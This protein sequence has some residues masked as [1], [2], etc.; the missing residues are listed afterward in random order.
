MT[1][2]KKILKDVSL[3]A[4]AS[5]GPKIM[6]FF[7]VPL[8]TS[9]LT[10]EAYGTADLLNTVVSLIL[11]I[12]MIDISD[13]IIIRTVE[14]RNEDRKSGSALKYGFTIYGKSAVVL[15]C[16]LFVASILISVEH[17]RFYCLYIFLQYSTLAIYNNLIAYLRG[18]DKAAI[19]VS[20]SLLHSALTIAL[21]I[22]LILFLDFGLLGLLI[23]GIVGGAITNI[24]LILR[25]TLHKILKSCVPISSEEKKGM[26]SYSIP[27]IF[28]GIAWWI[29]NSSDR[30]FI[31]C[32]HGVGLNGIYAIANKIP[33]ILSACHNI[34]YQALQLNVFSER[35][36][37]DKKEYY[38]RLY[39]IY[40]FLMTFICS[41]LI[42]FNKIL[43]HFLFK[44]DF[45]IAWKY[46]P[47]LLISV[48]LFSVSGYLTTLYAAE[49]ETKIIAKSTVTGALV[50]AF[51]NLIL[52]PKFALY[53]AV[54][55][56]LLGY[57]VIWVTMVSY[58]N[59]TLQINLESRI[60]IYGYLILCAQWL[61][62]LNT[63]HMMGYFIQS[64]GIVSLIVINKSSIK[65]LFIIF[66]SF[67][68][69]LKN[70]NRV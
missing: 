49:C 57:F 64:I 63:A 31:F 45:F 59:K 42:F 5:F 47:A 43:A 61:T 8:Y 32:F 65:I 46:T 22:I 29:N 52:I 54:T 16:V 2:T 28:T 33:T 15:A 51:L 20:G 6:N 27:L 39:N 41:L 50:N 3:F 58:S 11:P 68:A 48:V 13:A 67:M 12:L 35:Q 36:A 26:L 60:S 14:W 37:V 70:K 23:A 19:I 53:G 55:A 7:L 10:A 21:N 9:C 69:Q 62:L 1:R 56:T 25:L 4:I 40:N 38:Q 34:V 66:K 18:M 17:I 30:V 24:Y 44:G